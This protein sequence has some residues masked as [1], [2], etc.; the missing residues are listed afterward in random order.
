MS[1]TAGFTV[2]ALS[3]HCKVNYETIRYYEKI[4][5]L[6]APARS[7]NGYRRYELK[8]I[9][10]LFFIRRARELGFSLESI[11]ELL[12]LVDKG[13]CTCAKVHER[14]T[15]QLADIQG[16]IADLQRLEK[17]ITAMIAQCSKGKVPE[18]PVIDALFDETI[19]V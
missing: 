14:M 19:V 4:G 1:K 12:G 15:L 5:L 13:A 16:K 6:A 17:A 18:C 3:K 9:R 11:R 2:G 8:D 7:A 10:R